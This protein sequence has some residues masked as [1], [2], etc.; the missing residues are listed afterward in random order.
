MS[1]L[2]GAS[3]FVDQIYN[4]GREHQGGI[5]STKAVKASTTKVADLLATAV[6]IRL[7][8]ASRASRTV[9]FP[10]SFLAMMQVSS[11]IGISK[12]LR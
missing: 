10:A 9:D 7:K 5:Y 12:S 1:W 4:A 3:D 6:A 2:Q 11:E 8:N